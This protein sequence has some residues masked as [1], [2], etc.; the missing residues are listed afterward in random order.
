MFG[1]P[2][3]YQS[4][5]PAV[6]RENLETILAQV[7]QSRD[8]FNKVALEAKLGESL[9]HSAAH[10]FIVSLSLKATIGNFLLALAPPKSHKSDDPS[11]PSSQQTFETVENL[12]AKGP[13]YR[14]AWFQS[15][16]TAE[17]ASAVPRIG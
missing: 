6:L 9:D 2:S 7:D 4:D 17:A 16:A 11:K 15:W 13:D 3:I 1:T 10:C 5:D 12:D 8:V 14:A